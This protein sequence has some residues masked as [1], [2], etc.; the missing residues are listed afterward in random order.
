MRHLIEPYL[1]GSLGHESGFGLAVRSEPRGH[2]LNFYLDC[3][4]YG[5]RDA[6]IECWDAGCW[7]L[8]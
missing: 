7:V 5:V 8:G 1:I 6:R 4:V 2:N 3:D